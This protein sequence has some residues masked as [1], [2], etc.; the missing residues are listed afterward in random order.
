MRARQR[1]AVGEGPAPRDIGPITQ[2]DVVRFAGAGGDF[3][4][5]HHD[6]AFAAAAGFRTVI[7]MGQFQAGLL[8][9]FLTDWVGVENLREFDARFV[10]PV[11]LG[12]T[13]VL[14]AQVN[15]VE[16]GEAAIEL[17]ATVDGQP[18]VTAHARALVA[19]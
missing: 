13:L 7:A 1:L 14:S 10:A 3:N 5:L 8:A 16:N 17:S 2:T 6:P 9:A 18:V 19:D 4:P 11:Y 15:A 12:D